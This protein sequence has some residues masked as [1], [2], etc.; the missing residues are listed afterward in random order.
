VLAYFIGGALSISG[1]VFQSILRNSL[2]EPYILGV[3]GGGTFGAVLAMLIGLPFL[4][5]Q[6]MAFAG[7]IGVIGLVYLLSK[8]Y[9][10]LS[11]DVMLLTGVMISAFFGSLILLMFTF[12][13]DNLRDAIYWIIGSVATQKVETLVYI[14]PIIVVCSFLII[15]QSFKLNILS[16]G[17]EQ[18]KVLGLNANFIKKYFYI[19]TS[20]M[21]GT[22]VSISGLIGFVGLIIP[23]IV[24]LIFGLDNRIVL[25]ASFFIGA[26]YLTIADTISRTIIYP[27]ELPVGAITSIIGA[28]IFIFLLRRDKIK[29]NLKFKRM[30]IIF[31]FYLKFCLAR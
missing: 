16:L 10:E 21:V 8:R 25:P 18:A 30:G 7:S 29:K 9:G 13:G 5:V 15:I 20:L 6:A 24:R 1:G 14:I 23:H 4:G 31:T 3:S 27:V 12:L 22:V 28:P 11:S 19:I 17:D 26:I 2:A